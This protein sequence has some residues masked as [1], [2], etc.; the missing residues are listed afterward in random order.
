MK[1][2]PFL[3]VLVLGAAFTAAGTAHGQRD[4]PVGSFIERITMNRATGKDW[5]LVLLSP[6]PAQPDSVGLLTWVCLGTD[7]LDLTI[8]RPQSASSHEGR[9]HMISTF[10]S[11]PPDTL[12]LRRFSVSRSWGVAEED[13]IELTRRAKSSARL[14]IH[15]PGGSGEDARHEYDLS[16]ASAAL[17]RLECVRNLDSLLEARSRLSDEETY[18]VSALE[19]YPNLLNRP[20]F[21]RLLESSYPPE[22]RQAGVGGRVVVDFRILRD[23]SVDPESITI[24]SS[25]HE[26]LNEPTTR[27]VAILRWRPGKIARRAVNVRIRLPIDWQAGSR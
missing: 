11:Q 13:A 18:E 14:Q 8:R 21:G 22:L 12:V 16:G 10:D 4:V 20:E 24:V 6:A 25:A 9:Q 5:T 7:A 17:D 26:Q 27:A 23:G 15:V 19:E 2:S 1:R 3:V